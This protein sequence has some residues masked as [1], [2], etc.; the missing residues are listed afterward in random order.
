MPAV[1][2]RRSGIATTAQR[3]SRTRRVLQSLEQLVGQVGHPLAGYAEAPP[4]RGRADTHSQDQA[5]GADLIEQG[6]GAGQ[7]KRLPGGEQR[8]AG[9]LAEPGCRHDRRQRQEGRRQI[10]GTDALAVGL[11]HAKRSEP[12]LLGLRPSAR[13]RGEARADRLLVGTEV[14]RQSELDHAVSTA[15]RATTAATRLR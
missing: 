4:E 14:D 8:D 12:V 5:P 7:P 11:A 3:M 1:S 2:I 9:P 6:D 13:I 15:R 10:K